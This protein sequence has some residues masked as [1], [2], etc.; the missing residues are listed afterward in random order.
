ME[1]CVCVCCSWVFHIRLKGKL[2]SRLSRPYKLPTHRNTCN[3]GNS[4]RM[5]RIPFFLATLMVDLQ[6]NPLFIVNLRSVEF[7]SSTTAKLRIC[8]FFSGGKTPPPYPSPRW[9][10][11]TYAQRPHVTYGKNFMGVWR[12]LFCKVTTK[13]VAR[14]LRANCRSRGRGSFR[15]APALFFSRPS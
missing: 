3:A 7:Q 11:L 8:A 2:V 6:L 13:K 12:L 10:G 1:K 9:E 14:K 15:H 5:T 4:Y